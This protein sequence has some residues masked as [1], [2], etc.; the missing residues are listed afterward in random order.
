MQ[1]SELTLSSLREIAALGMRLALDDFGPGYSSLGYLKR[2][3]CTS[4]LKVDRS[5]I[6]AAPEDAN[7]V[8][9]NREIFGLGHSLGLAVIAEGIER[10]A[11]LRFL[12]AE[13]CQTAQGYWFN[14]PMPAAELQPLFSDVA[15][16]EGLWR[17]LPQSRRSAE[18]SRRRSLWQ[19]KALLA[20]ARVNFCG[21]D[22]SRSRRLPA[23][24]LCRR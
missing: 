9:I 17:L 14:R 6:A 19:A 22:D 16:F 8:A 10:P 12:I 4:S 11:Q 5:F 20:I 2:F 18:H 15:C 13:G 7:S 1:D 21:I 24:S 3:R 23:G